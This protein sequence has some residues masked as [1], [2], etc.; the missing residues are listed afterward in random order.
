MANP[1]ANDI[2][3]PV[4]LP[5]GNDLFDT[6]A[7]ETFNPPGKY[8]PSEFDKTVNKQYEQIVEGSKKIESI[9]IKNLAE[10]VKN[11]MILREQLMH[12]LID[13]ERF[14]SN[15]LVETI[16]AHINNVISDVPGVADVK[17]NK[18]NIDMRNEQNFDT[19]ER[20]LINDFKC[21]PLEIKGC[22]SNITC[23]IDTCNVW[24]YKYKSFNQFSCYMTKF[25]SLGYQMDGVKKAIQICQKNKT[26]I[27]QID[28]Q[29][30]QNAA[31]LKQY[32][33]IHELDSG[34]SCYRFDKK[35]SDTRRRR[36][37]FIVALV[38]FILGIF[39][40]FVP[41]TKDNIYVG[42]IIAGIVATATII[43]YKCDKTHRSDSFWY[44]AAYNFGY[45]PKCTFPNC[46]FEV[47][48][49]Q[50]LRVST[51][52]EYVDKEIQ[53]TCCAKHGI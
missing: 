8:I 53:K 33:G 24:P 18:T 42:S 25:D 5:E 28:D 20:M 38:V 45:T 49:K 10:M 32:M 6:F 43:D 51:P 19:I 4:I 34:L 41:Y 23:L 36:I 39:Y 48:N 27:P 2:K 22:I 14:V 46:T 11:D 26:K 35:L 13:L 12:E 21:D 7:F 52:P 1:S 30:A 9:R 3:I 29:I 37:K 15:K 44:D 40:E 50:R 47:N 16:K 17:Y 31:C